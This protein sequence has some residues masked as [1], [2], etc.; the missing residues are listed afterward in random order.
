VTIPGFQDI[1]LPVL[2]AV[3]SGDELRTGDLVREM[4]ET[5][6]LSPEER[7]TLLPSGTQSI[8]AN[9]THWAITYLS[10][11][12][13]LERTR[14][15][16]V[17]LTERGRTVLAQG[18]PKV[19]LN[20]L[21]QYPEL[22]AFRASRKL[23]TVSS[24]IVPIGLIEETDATPDE[25]IRS[26]YARIDAA[27]RELLLSRILKSPLAFFER[28]IVSLL[29][30]MGFG[31]KVDATA[32]AIGR[33]GDD[34]V[35][36]VIDQDALG[37]DRVYLQAKRYTPGNSVGPKAI[38]DFFGS[39]DIAKATKG[40]FI[41]TS[42]FTKSAHDTAGR[43]GKRIVLIDGDQLAALMIMYDVGVRIEETFHI[44]KID[45]DFFVD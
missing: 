21:A 41:T 9:R 5:F 18:P 45:E 1:M 14:R 32:E 28:L 20:F 36:G 8:I 12:K 26:A 2:R 19:D 40:V 27:L 3:A 4:E 42:T 7:E 29:V 30:A 37:L 39:L 23:N 6:H 33:S 17:R 44:K 34:G 13:L 25:L 31:G 35:D 10:K 24:D 22:D 43:L 16:Y 38:R 11:T 15:G